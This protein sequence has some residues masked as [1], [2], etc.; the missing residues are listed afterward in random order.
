[1]NKLQVKMARQDLLCAI[2]NALERGE[3]LEEAK[4]SLL[5]AGY[6]KLE[7]EEAAKEIENMKIK[8]KVPKPK[9]LPRLPK[10]FSQ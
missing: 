5:N 6:P 10:F 9:F 3:T 7:V 8:S 2:R 1:M 4:I